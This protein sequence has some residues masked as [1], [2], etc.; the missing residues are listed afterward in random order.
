MRLKSVRIQ[1][2]KGYEDTGPVQF[3]EGFNLLVGQNNSGKSAFL[4]G[5]LFQHFSSKSHRD[6]SR[7]PNGGPQ[8]ST[9][10]IEIKISGP[11]LR[12][13][14]LM[15]GPST[16]F[17]FM[18]P[19][20]FNSPDAIA[21]LENYL[22]RDTILT[23]ELRN[24]QW[25]APQA[26]SHGF[27]TNVQAPS[28][29]CAQFQVGE[30]Q[31][32]FFHVGMSQGVLNDNIAIMIAQMLQARGVYV[33][34]AERP[35]VGRSAIG[36]DPNLT[37]N[38]SNLPAVLLLLMNNQH[39][40]LRFIEHLKE[41]FPTIKS[42][43]AKPISGNEAVVLVW[44]TPLEKEREDL[45]I[46]LSESGTGI[47]QVLAILYVVVTSEQGRIIVI[48]EPNSFLHPGAARKLIEI[49]RTFKQHQYIIATHAPEIIRIA[50]PSI[51]HLVKW[52]DGAS[53]LVAMNPKEMTDA[54]DAL[55]EVGAR[56]SDVFG[57]DAVLWVEGPTEEICFPKI[58]SHFDCQIPLGTTVVALRNTGEITSRRPNARAIWDVYSR[59]TNANALMPRAI[60]FSLD[61]E[62]R[63]VAEQE[64]LRR[65]SGGLIHFLP[66]RTYENY[67]LDADAIARVLNEVVPERRPAV[68]STTV[69]E[70]IE[71]HGKNAEY[72]SPHGS[73]LTDEDW[74]LKVNAPKLL[75]DLFWD[76]SC[77]E[78]RKIVHSTRIT[79]WLLEYRPEALREIFDFLTRVLSS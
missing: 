33:F 53:H 45:A 39:R 64:E 22:T 19:Q 58:L 70:W 38:A 59:L 40:Y 52:E 8:I 60:A 20:Q 54:R 63:S 24:G 62:T 29:W 69:Q 6:L 49:L 43:T 74:K 78:Y 2:Y 27:F 34:R 67:L 10:G 21:N 11:E 75:S 13:F 31:R 12:S 17:Q 48:D 71:A 30:D 41:I 18:L 14:L 9:C 55:Q 46:E 72:V 25:N 15:R 37:S 26:P 51:L 1:N 28:P 76:L 16:T 65:I 7:A 68:A 79:E 61:L 35:N 36:T 4:E 57:A 44:Q 66:R 5:L 3:G 42:I 56:L 77:Q 73:G 50:E 47:G 23:A 32:R